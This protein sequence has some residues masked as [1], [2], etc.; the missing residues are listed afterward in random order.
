MRGKSSFE[1]SPVAVLWGVP[2]LRPG[3]EAH[4]IRCTG[5]RAGIAIVALDRDADLA[6]IRRLIV[7]ATAGD[8]LAVAPSETTHAH[9]D[10]VLQAFEL[11][12]AAVLP[13]DAPL[14]ELVATVHEL[15]AGREVIHPWSA[16]LVMRALRAR[17]TRGA[18]FSITAR[19]RDVLSL[20]VEG[21]TTAGIAVRLGVG[22]H[23]VQ[24]HLKSLY[25]K[26]DVGSKTAAT[27]LALR[28]QLVSG[29]A[30]RA[31]RAT[32]A[33]SPRARPAERR[34]AW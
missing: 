7:E 23:T 30:D 24:S 26:L 34:P 33:R 22:F 8:V 10:R 13:A 2:W 11:G 17:A 12:V 32:A 6:V 4:G 16:R 27:A 19:E 5:N 21:H 9:A 28:Y 3:L 14:A 25:R 1:A 29:T 15:H 31:A 18:R 20:L